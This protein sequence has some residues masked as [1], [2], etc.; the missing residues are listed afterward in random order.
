MLSPQGTA[1]TPCLRL[2]HYGAL[3][4]QRI[5]LADVCCE[6]PATGIDV[7]MGPVRA[8]KSTL[9]RS[10]ARANDANPSFR[11]WGVAELA[12]RLVD[13][14]HHP[15]LVQQ[16]SAVLRG[17]VRDAIVSEIRSGQTRSVRSWDEFAVDS[18]RQFGLNDVVEVIDEPVFSL[19]APLQRIINILRF[20][21]VSPHLL[22][23]DEPTAGLDDVAASYLVT[24]LRELGTRMKLVVSLHHQGQARQLADR[25]I[26]IG[27]GYV[28]AHAVT[29][30]FFSTTSCDVVQQFLRTGSLS[31]PAPDAAPEDLEHGVVPP[32]PLS[33]AA[34]QA[35]ASATHQNS[36]VDEQIVSTPAPGHQRVHSA[37]HSSP[38]TALRLPLTALPAPSRSGVEDASSVGLVTFS[39]HTGPRGFNWIVPGKLAGCPEPGIL[40]P[41]DYDLSLLK[42]TGVTCL[43]TLT[44]QN[45]DQAALSRH[46]LRNLHLP[47][48]D[49]EAPTVNQAYMLL[50]RMQRL[51]EQGEVLAVH[52]KAGLGRTGTIVAAWLIRDG[53]LSAATAIQRV[54]MVN[55]GYIQ[56]RLQEEF[57][58]ELEQDLINRIA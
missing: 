34:L 30:A 17:T 3:F 52:C 11:C 10:L 16:N 43:V 54:R 4:G 37:A 46:G 39:D 26:L 21:V 27:G 53:G 22:L 40:A 13:R 36:G 28:Q 57:L 44:E 9:F 58:E 12:G 25:I 50:I 42:E 29:A 35:L 2:V 55:R 6:I 38:T 31:L 5:V 41:L 33:A 32:R 49:R 47:V 51:L 7:L 1:E 48:F 8:G 24:W 56:S 14:E 18:L 15:L 23:V 19:P 45:L 20:A